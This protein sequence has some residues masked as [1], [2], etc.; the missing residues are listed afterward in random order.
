[1]SKLKSFKYKDIGQEVVYGFG[2]IVD[3]TDDKNYTYV[4]CGDRVNINGKYYG[5][6]SDENESMN[7]L[8][9]SLDYNE[10][11]SKP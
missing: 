4:F 11:P 9:D 1:L 2:L 3:Y 10:K 5:I 6:T 7:K 8:Y